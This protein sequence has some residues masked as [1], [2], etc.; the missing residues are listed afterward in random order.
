M[1]S[2]KY[3]RIFWFFWWWMLTEISNAVFRPWSS[4][5]HHCRKRLKRNWGLLEHWGRANISPGY[6]A[7]YPR[8]MVTGR[9][10]N[11]KMK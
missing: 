10:I 6:I 11:I 7:P 4:Q 3:R 5:S 8:V 9:V 2:M 1:D